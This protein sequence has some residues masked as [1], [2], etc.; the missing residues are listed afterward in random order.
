MK[1]WDI[2]REA[3]IPIWQARIK[4]CRSSELSVKEWCAAKGI[5]RRTYYKWESLCLERASANATENEGIDTENHSMI[6]INPALLPSNPE[7][8]TQPVA[9][10]SSELVIHCGCVS[11]DISSHMPV[12]RIAELVRALN[13]HV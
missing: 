12:T 10:I 8:G 5:D 11:M 4:E 3:A 1:A 2:K 7:P 6:Q 9:A 13:S